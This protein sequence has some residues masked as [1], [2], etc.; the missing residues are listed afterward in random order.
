MRISTGKNRPCDLINRDIV[1][2]FT[3]TFLLRWF[4]SV[5]VVLVCQALL[6]SEAC[7]DGSLTCYPVLPHLSHPKSTLRL[8]QN[9]AAV[10]V[11][12]Y[13]SVISMGYGNS[14]PGF[15]KYSPLKNKFWILAV[16]VAWILQLVYF[17]S[18]VPLNRLTSGRNSTIVTAVEDV[19]L[20][21]EGISGVAVVPYWVWLV[22]FLWPFF[23]L[24]LNELIKKF[25]L[26]E[27]DK[28]QKRARLQ[29]GTKLGMN[30]PF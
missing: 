23:L 26:A 22:G 24:P 29:F 28:Q 13:F 11:V 4:P 9:F 19:S 18:D 5:L 25:E 20:D 15:W 12:L 17:F 2:R 8:A 6:L 27:L 16:S 30:S 7:R 14:K 21:L 10:L 1:L 3:R